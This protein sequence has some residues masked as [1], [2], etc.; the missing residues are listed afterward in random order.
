[1]I[2][3]L[4]LATAGGLSLVEPVEPPF[5]YEYLTPKPESRGWF[6]NWIPESNWISDPPRLPWDEVHTICFDNPDNYYN[7]ASSADCLNHITRLNRP[8]PLS[9]QTGL[10]TSASRCKVPYSVSA[11]FRHPRSECAGACYKQPHFL[12]ELEN[13]DS[14]VG[15]AYTCRS[16]AGCLPREKGAACPVF[17]TPCAP[18]VDL[19]ADL[20]CTE[21]RAVLAAA[22]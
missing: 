2:L 9:L 14:Y 20:D 22:E 10:I 11:G 17:W 13:I 6:S 19:L 7:S 3:I 18:T 15:A 21:V 5:E 4:G 1:M 16:P 8:L 12:Y